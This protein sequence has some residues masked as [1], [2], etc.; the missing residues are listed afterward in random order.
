ME[1]KNYE[2]MWD[3]AGAHL[4]PLEKQFYFVSEPTH[5]LASHIITQIRDKNARTMHKY[6]LFYYFNSN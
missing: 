2:K 6:N 4:K 5:P 3:E 1:K